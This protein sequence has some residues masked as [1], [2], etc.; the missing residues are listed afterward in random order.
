M[1]QCRKLCQRARLESIDFP[2]NSLAPNEHYL[3]IYKVNWIKRHLIILNAFHMTNGV[4]KRTLVRSVRMGMRPYVYCISKN[5]HSVSHSGQLC[6]RKAHR[7]H[8]CNLFPTTNAF[9]FKKQQHIPHADW[10]WMLAGA[11]QHIKTNYSMNC[12]I[13]VQYARSHQAN[14]NSGADKS[15]DWEWTKQNE[16][17]LFKLAQVL[18]K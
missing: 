17:K 4:C 5:R 10:R 14:N 7:H 13:L 2:F 15:E 9:V 6:R 18:M 3:T 16:K 1:Y 12:A 11:H 8:T